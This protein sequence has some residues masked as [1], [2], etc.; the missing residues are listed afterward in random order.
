MKERV[1]S[2]WHDMKLEDREPVVEQCM[3][4]SLEV[5]NDPKDKDKKITTP[6]PCRRI[7][8]DWKTPVKE[9]EEAPVLRCSTYM[10]PEK[11]WRVYSCPFAQ[12][13]PTGNQERMLNP[14][15]ASKRAAGK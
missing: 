8:G 9:G 2:A 5:T 7:D 11:K 10:S 12:N 14:L 6:I 13:A 1:E 15:K 3:T 4:A